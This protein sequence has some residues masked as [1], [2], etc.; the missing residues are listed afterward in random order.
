MWVLLSLWHLSYRDFDA[1]IRDVRK[2]WWGQRSC[3]RVSGSGRTSSP[4][5]GCL[6][7]V[8]YTTDAMDI[9]TISGASTNHPNITKGL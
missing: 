6:L 2:V 1:R 7:V 3:D 9:L 8:G 5:W 4:S